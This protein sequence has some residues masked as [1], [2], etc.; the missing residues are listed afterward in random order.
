[1]TI[2]ETV[3][4]ATLVAVS[5]VAAISLSTNTQK[6][7]AYSRNLSLANKYN[8]GALDSLKQL[9]S[10]MGWLAFIG[11][12][13]GDGGSPTY[14]FSTLPSSSTAFAALTAKSPSDCAADLIEGT[15][16][17]RVASLTVSN[18]PNSVS[19]TVTTYFGG[20]SS[21]SVAT[22]ATLTNY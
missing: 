16:F 5:I 19:V 1:M 22:E 9:R 11:E 14:C 6:E 4:A 2:L 13:E 21:R 8:A 12:L 3:I 18:P 15:S 17:Y 20:D 7:T 10:S